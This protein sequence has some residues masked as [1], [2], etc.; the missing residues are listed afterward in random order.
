MSGIVGYGLGPNLGRGL[1][2]YVVNTD[3]SWP[4]FFRVD[5]PTLSLRFDLT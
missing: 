3:E 5:T 2:G 4:F 1:S